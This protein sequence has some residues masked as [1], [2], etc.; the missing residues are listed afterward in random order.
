M[1]TYIT[2]V[3]TDMMPWVLRAILK[4]C[5]RVDADGER[6]IMRMA[7][8][9][10]DLYVGSQDPREAVMFALPMLLLI[11]MEAVRGVLTI[12][13]HCVLSGDITSGMRTP[14]VCIPTFCTA[15]CGCKVVVVESCG[16]CFSG[17]LKDYQVHR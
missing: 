3:T 14:Q 5:R 17:D 6:K 11:L 12:T 7:G 10:S 16:Q 15:R 1:G 4:S 9:G 13:R 2:I 8:Q